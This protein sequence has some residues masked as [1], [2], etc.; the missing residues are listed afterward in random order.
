MTDENIIENEKPLSPSDVH[1]IA[2][3]SE[4]SEREAE[5]M[6][7]EAGDVTYEEYSELINKIMDAGDIES[8]IR[9]RKKYDALVEEHGDMILNDKRDYTPQEPVLTTRE[10]M[11]A[12]AKKS[13]EAFPETHARIQEMIDMGQK[14]IN[15][16]RYDA[17]KDGAREARKNSVTLTLGL[18]SQIKDIIN[19]ENWRE[20]GIETY[21]EWL[22]AVDGISAVI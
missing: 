19:E 4:L 18:L 14:R 9:L 2:L 21:Q 17:D 7:G 3:L 15:Q 8:A 13:K 12:T 20:A 11:N 16:L 5:V 10:A 1:A 6:F 22:S